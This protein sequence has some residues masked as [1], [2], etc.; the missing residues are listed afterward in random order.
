MS[1]VRGEMKTND[2]ENVNTL[3]YKLKPSERNTL[4]IA[5]SNS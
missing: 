1:N 3:I 2:K 5:Q 4:H